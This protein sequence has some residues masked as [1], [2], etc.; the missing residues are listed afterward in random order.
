VLLLE[1]LQLLQQSQKFEPVL[2]CIV[3]VLDFYE[4]R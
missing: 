3:P 1:T 2:L 4:R